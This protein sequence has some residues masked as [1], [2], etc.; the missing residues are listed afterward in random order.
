MS[1]LSTLVANK[2]PGRALLR[3]SGLQ[4]FLC[5]EG[6][7]QLVG[8]EGIPSFNV[9]CDVFDD[10]ILNNFLQVGGEIIIV[11]HAGIELVIP[12]LI[13]QVTFAS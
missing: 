6:N 2:R 3:V 11:V 4:G 1:F 8:D 5:F 7:H 9:P 12:I 10:L 13:P